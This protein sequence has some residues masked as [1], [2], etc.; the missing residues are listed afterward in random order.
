MY[1]TIK[2][3]KKEKNTDLFLPEFNSQHPHGGSQ[4][5]SSGLQGHNNQNTV[6]I[7]NK[8]FKKLRDCPRLCRPSQVFS[9]AEGYRWPWVAE[10][11]LAWE[12]LVST[13]LVVR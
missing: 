4:P 7:L 8:F 13:L 9:H 3:I 10:R 5:P 2:T 1:S 11:F 12:I 6:Y